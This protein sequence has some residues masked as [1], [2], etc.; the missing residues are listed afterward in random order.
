MLSDAQILQIVIVANEGEVAEGEVASA[1]AS[2]DTVKAFAQEMIDDH[3]Q[4]AADARAVATANA[5]TPTSSAVSAALEA[6]AQATV[7][8]LN[9]LGEPQFDGAYMASQV[10]AH[11]S[12][13]VLVNDALL[14]QAVN[15]DLRAYLLTMRT[16]VQTHLTAA[17]QIAADL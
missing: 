15:T 13:L 9:S 11:Q 3:T 8:A 2:H 7:A 14:P 6:Q 12:V 17:A 4:A 5:I 16:A 1:K 10:N